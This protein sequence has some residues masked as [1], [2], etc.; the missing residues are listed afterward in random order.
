MDFRGFSVPIIP[1]CGR[2]VH[3]GA[4]R[5]TKNLFQLGMLNGAR[6]ECIETIYFVNRIPERS[7]KILQWSCSS[8]YNSLNLNDLQLSDS[9]RNRRASPFIRPFEQKPQAPSI[10]IINQLR[11]TLSQERILFRAK[12]KA[13][14]D[15]PKDPTPEA[16]LKRCA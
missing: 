3:H 10:C 5:T 12:R 13:G 11:S 2:I 7:A 15:P 4:R 8:S 1:S 6:P 16:A 9:P 14:V